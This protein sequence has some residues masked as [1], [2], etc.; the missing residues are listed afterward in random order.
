MSNPTAWLKFGLQ[1]RE[2]FRNRPC[3]TIPD[4]HDIGQGNLWGENGKKA[5]PT[6]KKGIGDDGGYFYDPEYVKMVERCQ[7]SHLPD[8][9]DPTPIEQGIN[10]YYTNLNYFYF[11]SY[12]KKTNETYNF[13]FFNF[14]PVYVKFI[15]EIESSG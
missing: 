11:V 10:V 14:P 3:I 9:F 2:L 15:G 4:D 7:T 6:A 13:D 5:D 1:F 8:P 12:M